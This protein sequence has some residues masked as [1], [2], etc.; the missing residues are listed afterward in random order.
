MQYCRLI[1]MQCQLFSCCK[2]VHAT[3]HWKTGD[4]PDVACIPRTSVFM[5]DTISTCLHA[6]IPFQYQLLTYS[7]DI[8]DGCG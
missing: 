5:P 3:A 8:R 7:S 6:A 1:N 4:A 2:K